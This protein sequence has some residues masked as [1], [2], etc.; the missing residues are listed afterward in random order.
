VPVIAQQPYVEARLIDASGSASEM[1]VH[2]R[3][4]AGRAAGIAGAR[5]LAELLD[6]ASGATA[7]EHLLRYPFRVVN[8]QTAEPGSSRFSVGVL[9]FETDTAD[10]YAIIEI[11]GIKPGLIDPDDDTLLL[12]TAEPLQNYIDALINGVF[13][14]RFGYNL[15][16]CIAGLYQIRQ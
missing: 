10:Q 1:Q 7:V 11:P 2:V 13:S 16:A 8:E 4:S 3:A 12:L 6:A 15:T 14:N 5:Q 9:I